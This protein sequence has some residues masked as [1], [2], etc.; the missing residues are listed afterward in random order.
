[1]LKVF[2]IKD[3]YEMP[4][5]ERAFQPGSIEMT[6]KSRKHKLVAIVRF[7]SVYEAIYA[8]DMLVE[9]NY[10][11]N[12]HKVTACFMRNRAK[13]DLASVINM[14]NL[15]IEHAADSNDV[16]SSNNA[17]VDKKP[18]KVELLKVKKEELME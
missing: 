16:S 7:K 14:S 1:M 10:M 17:I 18:I 13:N 6:K 4:H 5:V 12:N 15:K 9:R 11:V 3:M 8:L 2:H